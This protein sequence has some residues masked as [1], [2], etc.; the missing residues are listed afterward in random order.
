MKIIISCSPSAVLALV[1]YDGKHTLLEY[2]IIFLKMLLKDFRPSESHLW[3]LV[4]IAD[5]V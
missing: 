5:V 3:L 4:A 1:S 2:M